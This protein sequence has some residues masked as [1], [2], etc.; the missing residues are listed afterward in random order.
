MDSRSGPEVPSK[1]H[2]FGEAVKHCS[3]G[4][5]KSAKRMRQGLVLSA[6]F[7]AACTPNMEEPEGVM[8]V[9][10]QGCAGGSAE[11][12]FPAVDER[13]RFALDAIVDARQKA[14]KLILEHYPADAQKDALA[15]LGGELDAANGAQ[16]F[17]RRC[18]AACVRQLCDKVGAVKEVVEAGGSAREQTTR[19]RT[20]RGGEYVLYRTPKLRYGVVFETD[21]LIRER[22]RAFAALAAIDANTKIYAR[23][24]AL[25]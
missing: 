13:S 11:A 20:V 17:A 12:L 21:A 1:V 22:R 9:L 5:A 15:E 16:L 23:Q 8:G 18:P 3:G 14:Q 4:R 25:R 7:L 6:M 24:K 2:G 19:V 10:A